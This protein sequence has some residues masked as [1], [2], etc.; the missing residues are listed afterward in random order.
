MRKLALSYFTR[1]KSTNKILNCIAMQCSYYYTRVINNSYVI[2]N[3]G[4]I[5]HVKALENQFLEVTKKFVK[6][7]ISKHVP[8]SDIIHTLSSLPVVL[9]EEHGTAVDDLLPQ[10]EAAD[11][12]NKI[13]NRVGRLV[14]FIDYQLIEYLIEKY[15]DRENQETMA[16]YC[17]EVEVFLYCTKVKDLID[18]WPGKAE[19]PETFWEVKARFD[20]DPKMYSLSKLNRFRRNFCCKLKLCEMVVILIRIEAG[21]FIAVF[22]LPRLH[23]EQNDFALGEFYEDNGITEVLL[24][25]LQVYPT[26]SMTVCAEV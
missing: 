13:F 11:S 4:T 15:G 23:F 21:S 24:D 20:G 19:I 9:H 1:C 2:S 26:V 25:G 16:K 22:R 17:E 8:C 10:L 18:Y 5:N 14:S 12:I 3:T 6:C 7:L